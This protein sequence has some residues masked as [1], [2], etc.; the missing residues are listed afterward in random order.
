MC[1]SALERLNDPMLDVIV[2]DN[3]AGEGSIGALR[4]QFPD[5]TMVENQCNLGF[6]GGCNVGIRTALDRGAEYVL[7]LNDDAEIDAQTLTGLLATAES[8]EHIGMV[9][10]TIY[11]ARPREI[12]WSAGGSIDWLGRASHPNADGPLT[13]PR[14]AVCDVDYVTGCVLLVKRSVIE[15]IGALDERFFAYYEE[16]EWCAR[17]RRT[18]FRVVHVPGARAWHRITPSERGESPTYLY[19]MARNR[20]LYLTAT[21]APLP[22]VM[23]A[24]MDTLR[25]ALSWSV[26][27]CHRARRS[28]A[29]LLRQAVRDFALGRF[30]PP[31]T[32]VLARAHG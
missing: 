28:F 30:G 3:S 2:V 23:L 32:T 21:G 15:T 19:L 31:P 14:S 7:L 11:Y 24:V 10:P 26:R 27:P 25:T 8:D 20:L 4:L 16:A 5:V 29:G 12:V 17:A 1:L 6:A 13:D 9:G 22:V 18:G